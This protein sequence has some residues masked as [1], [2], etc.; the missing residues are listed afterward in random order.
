MNS[1]E[2]LRSSRMKKNKSVKNF[3]KRAQSLAELSSR[4]NVSF[5]RDVVMDSSNVSTPC[6]ENPSIICIHEETPVSSKNTLVNNRPQKRKEWLM[7][8]PI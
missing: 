6:G 1:D 5:N 8:S 7:K 3:A 2:V 4:E